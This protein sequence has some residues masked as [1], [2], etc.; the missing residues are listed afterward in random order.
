[1]KGVMCVRH[2]DI[3]Y[4]DQIMAMAMQDASA[5]RKVWQVR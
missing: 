4:T 2:G 1:M 3:F 5:Q